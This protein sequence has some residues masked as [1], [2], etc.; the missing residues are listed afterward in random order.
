MRKLVTS[1]LLV[2][3]IFVATAI[4]A[5]TVVDITT[6]TADAGACRCPL[7]YAPVICSNG[8]TYPNQCVADCHHA[9]GCVPLPL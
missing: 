2:G 6:T 7:V 8:K 3:A 9:S 4:A 5:L 1:A